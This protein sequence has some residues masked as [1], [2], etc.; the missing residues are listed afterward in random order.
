MVYIKELKHHTKKEILNKLDNNE[1]I[2]NKLIKNNFIKEENEQYS[3]NYVGIIIIGNI[4]IKVYP[5]YIPNSETENNIKEHFKQVIKVIKKDISSNKTKLENKE[6]IDTSFNLLSLMLFFLEDYYENGLYTSMEDILEINGNGEIHWDK[7]INNY[8][9]ILN[10]NQPY[11]V[12]LETKSKKNDIYDYYRLLHEYIITECSKYLE[13]QELLDLFGL[14]PVELTNKTLE[15]FGEKN[16]ILEKIRKELN[17]VFN[18]QKRK[19]LQSI[20][21]LLSEQN[22]FNQENYITTYGTN[23][24]YNTW[25]NICCN[26]LNDKLYQPLGKLKLPTKL[27]KK[28][29]ATKELIELIQKPTWNIDN[30]KYIPHK[31]LIPDIITIHK[32]EF[33]ILDAKYY[34][35]KTKN[36]LIENQPGIDSITKQ[37]L[38]ELT[39]K[40]F[41]KEHKFKKVKNGFLFPKYTEGIEIKGHVHFNIMT[42]MNLQDILIILLPV[43]EIFDYYLK[44]KKIKLI[45][46]NNN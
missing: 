44:N 39:F 26:I 12:E 19:I 23:T 3:F 33:T 9:P 4:V 13:K 21:S 11:F 8:T 36:N 2:L 29:D 17:I 16:I 40:E 6:S 27:N 46:Q 28:Y 5:K 10:H 25:E 7:T 1:E 41:I 35:Y 20:Y 37:Y 24:F 38:Y 42:S 22:P 30:K 34:V 14:T 45:I 32:D 15:D 43:K 18:T 31:T